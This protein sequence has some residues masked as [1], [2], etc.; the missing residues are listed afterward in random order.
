MFEMADALTLPLFTR[1]PV[2]ILSTF[3]LQLVAVCFDADTMEIKRFRRQCVGRMFIG[4]HAVLGGVFVSDMIHIVHAPL[5][6]VWMLKTTSAV[7]IGT[8]IFLVLVQYA[9]DRL[10]LAGMINS[11][12]DDHSANT[13]EKIAFTG[14]SDCVPN[15]P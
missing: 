3:L 15:Q 14:Q 6:Y 7:Y 9:M 13:L 10:L 8:S 12:E 11:A 5:G 1:D 2:L 4:T